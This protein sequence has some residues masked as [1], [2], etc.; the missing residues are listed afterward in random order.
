MFNSSGV[1]C[2]LAQHKGKVD[3]CVCFQQPRFYVQLFLSPQP[4]KTRAICEECQE[5]MMVA[6]SKLVSSSSQL[7][8]YLRSASFHAFVPC[9]RR[10]FPPAY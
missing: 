3:V 8:C 1:R 2:I 5:Q 10:A 7:I 6:F 4:R 9:T